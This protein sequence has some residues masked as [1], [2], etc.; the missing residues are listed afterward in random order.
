MHLPKASPEAA[1]DLLHQ[2][3]G[4]QCD[5]MLLT[6]DISIGQRVAADLESLAKGFRFP[7]YVVLGNH[8]F[9]G[10]TFEMVDATVNAKCARNA[11]LVHLGG[12]EII[13]LSDSTALVGHRGWSDGRGGCNAVQSTVKISD[14]KFIKDFAFKLRS[15]QIDLMEQMADESAEYFQQ[16]LPEAMAQYPNVI[17]ATHVP[18]YP[19]ASWHEG[20][21]SGEEYMPFYCNT[22]AGRAID[23]VAGRFPESKLTIYCGHTHSAG[24]YSPLPNVRVIT[25]DATY[26][27]PKINRVLEI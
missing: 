11:N 16:I 20:K 1:R 26:G 5:A 6:G 12:G 25:G 23:E 4:K 3:V 2:M 8:D 14:F 9:Y 24:E 21:L 15:E 17:V 22:A 7:V 18:P 27:A 10:S 19:G 13:R